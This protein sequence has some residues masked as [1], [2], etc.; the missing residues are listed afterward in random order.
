MQIL[1]LLLSAAVA[2]Q[3]PPTLPDSLD[4]AAALRRAREGNPVVEAA[5]AGGRSAAATVAAAR[6]ERGPRISADLF[7]LRYQD[8]A[9]VALGAPGGFAPFLRDNLALGL[10]VGQ[11]VYTGGRTGA[12]IR[13]AEAGRE[14]AT[15]RARA[16]VAA[17]DATVT[18]AFDDVL[19]ARA[20]VDVSEEGVG[21]LE[22]AVRVAREQVE[23]GAVAR[24]DVLRAETRLSSARAERRSARDA[25]TDARERLAMVLG[26]DEPS[27]PPVSGALTAVD[28][29]SVAQ[30]RASAAR[31]GEH[32]ALRALAAEARAREAEARF[33]RGGRRP[34]VGLQIGALST[35]P[36][37]MT[38]RSEWGGELYAA[39]VLSWTFFDF[40]RSS[41]RAGASIADADRLRA[42][43]GALE[44]SLRAAVRVETRRLERSLWEV[45]DARANVARAEQVLDLARERYREGVGIQLEVLEA[46]AELVRIRADLHRAVHASRTAVAEV[47]RSLG[48]T[49]LEY[50][51][52]EAEGGEP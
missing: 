21:V 38:G 26:L 42:V 29:D 45:E 41:S 2:L 23:S 8:P 20:L 18:K 4:H 5:E 17:V 19:L 22:E 48:R 47:R 34:H 7:Y 37:L 43:E 12:A 46:Q 39:V 36:E 1:S 11:P 49:V 24:I 44:D 51:M 14:A 10:R 28:A 9:E 35:R 31:V 50:P 16:A 27:L 6:A 25:V 33:A 30:L 52:E 40:G 13:A 32:A 3:G 15:Y